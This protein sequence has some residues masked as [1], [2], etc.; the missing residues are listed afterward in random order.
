MANK[1]S[2][3]DVFCK[4]GF[5]RNF[6]KFTGKHLCLRLATFLK[7]RLWHRC[8]PVKF[9]KFLRTPF[10]AEHIL[11]QQTYVSDSLA[12]L[13]P[14]RRQGL[15]SNSDV[16][17]VT[18]K[19]LEMGPSRHPTLLFHLIGTFS[20]LYWHRLIRNE[21]EWSHRPLNSDRGTHSYRSP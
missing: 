5:L 11:L 1:S 15:T 17:S 10:L 4:K 8:F 3:P 2:R 21:F 7:K 13:A 20:N 16:W 6:P 9:S 14:L 12:P 18:Y 19:N